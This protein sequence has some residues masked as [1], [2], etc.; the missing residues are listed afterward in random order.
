MN[1]CN[2]KHD[3][4]CF[5]GREC[6]LCEMLDGKNDDINDLENQ[7]RELKRELVV[8]KEEFETFKSESIGVIQ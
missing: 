3:E 2:A 4:I 5:N 7:I 6:P 8:L 1:L